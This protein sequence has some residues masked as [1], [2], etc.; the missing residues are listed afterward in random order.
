LYF[1]IFAFSYSLID[2]GRKW[3]VQKLRE[4]DPLGRL[5]LSDNVALEELEEHP[6]EAERPPPPGPRLVITLE[7]GDFTP[8]IPLASKSAQ[9]QFWS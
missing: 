7:C 2:F 6:A 4:R 9:F 1:F 8:T 3:L 5:E